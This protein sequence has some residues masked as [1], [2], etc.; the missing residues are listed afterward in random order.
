MSIPVFVINLDR[1]EDRLAH[2]TREFERVGM[3]FERFPGVDRVALPDSVKAYF[4]DPTGR[5]VSPLRPGEIGCYAS[6]L[7]VWQRIVGR[8][9]VG[10]VLVCEDDMALPDG[11]GALVAS[12]VDHAPRGWSLINLS[13]R[14]KRAVVPMCKVA[15]G[16]QL[17]RFSRDPGSLAAYLINKDGARKL[18][19]GGIRCRQV[20]QDT[21]R[22][23]AF[24]ISTFGLWPPLPELDLGSTND[25]QPQRFAFSR[26]APLDVVRRPVHGI[27]TLNL[28]TWARCAFWNLVGRKLDGKG[29]RQRRQ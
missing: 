24:G 19:Q 25:A 22:P 2:I 28:A 10:A 14:T 9:Y 27:R 15:N 17:V 8:D 4:C 5:I 18:L 7:S 1:S 16:H 6:H 20:D 29:R 13:G 23:W 26:L 11:F 21:R 3:A 12:V